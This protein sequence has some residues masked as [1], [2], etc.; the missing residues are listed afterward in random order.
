MNKLSFILLVLACTMCSYSSHA[1]HVVGGN[2]GIKWI[3]DSTYVVQIRV[4]RDCNSFQ[5]GPLPMSVGLTM[6]KGADHSKFPFYDRDG[7]LRNK[8]LLK[9][10]SRIVDIPLG[11][12]CYKPE[13]ICVEEGIYQDTIMLPD[14]SG[15]LYL[16]CEIYSRNEAITNLSNPGSVGMTFYAEI[17]DR[18]YKNSS[19]DFGD[20]PTDGYMCVGFENNI[21]VSATD[22]DSDSIVYKLVDPLN[23]NIN[24][25]GDPYSSPGPYSAAPWKAPYNIGNIVGGTPPLTINSKT[26]EIKCRPDQVGLFVVAIAAE[27]Y[28]NG[29]KI[30]EVR[31]D[32]QLTA[33][34]DCDL[35]PKPK[36]YISIPNV[37]A[38]S[39]GQIEIYVDT[40]L[41]F[42]LMAKG[43]SYDDSL[44]FQITTPLLDKG[45]TIGQSTDTF[46]TDPY[47]LL[48]YTF[49]EEEN[50][51][52]DTAKPN[53]E[54]DSVTF[55]QTGTVGARICWQPTCA[56]MDSTIPIK[57][58]AYKNSTD[59]CKIADTTDI[60][61]D[62][63]VRDRPD[64]VPNFLMKDSIPKI[65]VNEESY[66]DLSCGDA[67]WGDSLFF[68]IESKV[69]TLGAT[70]EASP[71][72]V[73]E[74]DIGNGVESFTRKWTDQKIDTNLSNDSTYYLEGTD[75]IATQ[76]HWNLGCEAVGGTYQLTVHAYSVSPCGDTTKADSR[77]FDVTVQERPDQVPEFIMKDENPTIYVNEESCFDLSS[78]DPDAGD[79]LFFVVESELFNYGADLG[80]SPTGDYEYDTG[81]GV[82]SF[83]TDWA[84]QKINTNIS[85]DSMYFLEGIDTIASR[86]CWTPDCDAVGGTF[87]LTI[88]AFSITYCGDTT[89]ADSRSFDVKVEERPDQAPEFL[90]K[91]ENPIIYI[92]EES[93]FDLSSV[94]PDEGDSLFFVVESELFSFGADLG[95]SPTGDY[96]YDTGN[97]VAS[98][99]TDWTNQKINTN[100]SND[101]I[102]FLEGIDTIATRVCWS[103]GC[104]AEGK[105]FS[106]LIHSFSVTD[107]RDTNWADSKNID[108]KIEQ[109]PDIPPSILGF[110]AAKNP[111]KV[112]GGV[113]WDIGA[114]DD[115]SGDT[116]HLE[117]TSSTFDLGATTEVQADNEYEFWESDQDWYTYNASNQTKTAIENGF[118]F[119]DVD[120]VATRFCWNT[121]CEHL[122]DSI[123]S[124]YDLKINVYSVSICG[125]TAQHADYP[126]E[127]DII[128]IPNVDTG[129]NVLPNIF[130]PNGDNVNDLFYLPGLPDPCNDEFMV[131][132]YNRWGFLIYESTSSI[133]VWDGKNKGGV[134]VPEGT[135]F[136]VVEGSKGTFYPKPKYTAVPNTFSK[137]VFPVTLKR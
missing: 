54:I 2:W 82:E 66:F 135:Y 68:T 45:M 103:P 84:N 99:N 101:S 53:I 14:S 8:I 87:K 132:I 1:K 47:V 63:I 95:P 124:I 25:P 19:P 104:D 74:Y 44:I 107:C 38:N 97:G 92:N 90:M 79:S 46:Q 13:N 17:P 102:Y 71:T 4:Y 32:I 89:S 12:D 119:S 115:D 27:E 120:T 131:K 83:N 34:A 49:W 20:Y 61:F 24:L 116:L 65:Y 37:D 55:L 9:R 75:T 123:V 117:V 72:D 86:V 100:L 52:K 15:M 7:N 21:T 108:V 33:I 56:D 59:T 110:Y 122:T 127:L 109:R 29:V 105:T 48:E 67:D 85:N 60:K 133:F 30:G 42:D 81:N 125:D 5:S 129:D 73:Y 6:Y 114:S 50:W 80:P 76:I 36:I 62:V 23:G 18:S 11:D 43:E 28:R 64:I 94:D 118:S 57:I 91:D 113:C 16:S 35:E 88:G 26:G 3:S 77:S 10:T 136:V 112:G 130:T 78:V 41:C 31:R 137:N 58:R 22:A 128:V 134:D 69:F 106:V 70:L 126:I 98:F 51:V 121:N 40:L 39:D 93:C 96:E 111:V